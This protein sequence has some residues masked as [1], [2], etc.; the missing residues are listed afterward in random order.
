MAD[1]QTGDVKRST[2][3]RHLVEMAEVAS[4]QMRFRS[5]EI[6]WPL[7]ELWV[8]GTL[9]EPTDDIDHGT[10][11]LMID[12]AA[13]E[14][15]WL[16]VHPTA[17]QVGAQLRLGKRPMWWSY[18]PTAWPPW[19]Y[20]HRQ[21][22]RF[23]SATGGLDRSVID[24]LRTGRP[25]G[26]IAPNTHE[27]VEQLGIELDASKTHLRSVLNRY[28]DNDWR[29]E[30]RNHTSPEDQLWRAATAVTEIEAAIGEVA[31]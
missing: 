25:E 8:A 28:W 27:L 6:G 9:L 22:E 26:V 11:V 24:A 17:E 10:V 1:G 19:T 16:A 14:L 29:R 13:D 15:A 20:R 21:V 7:E 30:N 5:T 4:D 3:I 18:R 2:A 23:W 12:L 31:R